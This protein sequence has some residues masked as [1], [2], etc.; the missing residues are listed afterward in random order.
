MRRHLLLGRV[1]LC[2]GTRLPGLGECYLRL[3]GCCWAVGLSALVQTQ[4]QAW[5]VLLNER[6]S[7]PYPLAACLM[8]PLTIGVRPRARA[9]PTDSSPV[10]D[11]PN[12]N[13]TN[14]DNANLQYASE[15]ANVRT[16]FLSRGCP[17]EGPQSGW[18]GVLPPKRCVIGTKRMPAPHAG[19]RAQALKAQSR[20]AHLR[21]AP[22]PPPRGRPPSEH[23]LLR[24]TSCRRIRIRR[25]LHRR[26]IYRQLE[27]PGN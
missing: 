1:L 14:L 4:R 20:G 18:L 13:V 23:V 12:E 25:L 3:D 22:P 19:C 10:P 26:Q 27:R 8:H 9:L 11:A 6:A 24:H 17:G 7:K 15:E 21:S 2:L 16:C 5:H